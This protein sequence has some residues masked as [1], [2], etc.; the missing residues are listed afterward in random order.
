MIFFFDFFFVDLKLLIDDW[1][2]LKVIIWKCI[3]FARFAYFFAIRLGLRNDGDILRKFEWSSSQSSWSTS[4]GSV[5][6]LIVAFYSRQLVVL[7]IDFLQNSH[8]SFGPFFFSRFISR[9]TPT[10]C[11]FLIARSLHYWFEQYFGWVWRVFGL[12]WHEIV[13]I[14]GRYCRVYNRSGRWAGA[15]V[16]L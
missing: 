13:C 4:S 15:S 6:S 5:F 3:T 16:G 10:L 12:V 7:Q 1:K 14:Y 11:T 9:I 8:D 2:K